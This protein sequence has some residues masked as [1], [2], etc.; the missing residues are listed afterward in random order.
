MGSLMLGFRSQQR[1]RGLYKIRIGEDKKRL[2]FDKTDVAEEC[3][4]EESFWETS[5]A[6][7]I[8]AFRLR[9]Q[10]IAVDFSVP[11]RGRRRW[12]CSG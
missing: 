3:F 12:D 10:Q 2:G 8:C 5:S 6:I 1:K 11:G 7:L 9:K 4:P